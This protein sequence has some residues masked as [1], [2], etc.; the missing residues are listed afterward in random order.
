M[1][2]VFAALAWVF[3]ALVGLQVFFAGIGIF[4]AGDIELHRGFG[5]LLPMVALFLLLPAAAATRAGRLTGLVGGLVVLV[6]VQTMLPAFKADAP[7]IAAL[8]PV[9]ALAIAAL[10]LTIAQR[11]TALARQG[12]GE[13]T[14]EEAPAAPPA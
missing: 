2:T 12:R 10:T 3:L 1:R 5:W 13:R 4:G 9:N 6:I 7:Y 8:H 14:R 11:A